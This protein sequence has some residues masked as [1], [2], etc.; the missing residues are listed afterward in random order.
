MLLVFI[1]SV[2]SKLWEVM[3]EHSILIIHPQTTQLDLQ[4]RHGSH[5][6]AVCVQ[7]LAVLSL[8]LLKEWLR[9]IKLSQR[10]AR[11]YWSRGI[12]DLFIIVWQLRD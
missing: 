10:I 11:K 1:D 5:V 8:K 4:S 6:V 7:H 3:S 2:E 12:S 9:N